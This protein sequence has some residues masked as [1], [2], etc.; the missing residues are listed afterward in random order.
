MFSHKT[1][2]RTALLIL[3]LTALQPQARAQKKEMAQAKTSIKSGKNLA[4]AEKLMTTLLQ[5]TANRTNTKIWLLLFETVKKQYEQANEKFYLHQS[6]DTTALFKAARR[7]FEVAEQ[8]DSIDAAPRADGQVEPKYRRK[9][10]DYLSPYRPN[11]LNGG[12]YFLGKQDFPTAY[13]FLDTYIGCASAPLFSDFRYA[14]N[15]R[16]LSRAAQLT[17]YCGLKQQRPD[18]ALRH[19]ELARRDTEHQEALLQYLAEV[20]K[21][22]GDTA[23]YVSTLREGFTLAPRSLYF[24]PH[25]FD[26]YFHRSDLTAAEALCD[27]ALQVAPTDVVFRFAKSSVLLSQTRYAECIALSDSLIAQN[28]SLADAYL[29]AGLSYYYQGTAIENNTR[30]ARAQRQQMLGYYRQALPYLQRYRTLQPETIDQW[31]LPLYTIYLN[32][33]MGKEF[34]EVDRLLKSRK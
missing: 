12:L 8:F 11:L 25:L 21:L 26:H 17:V 5:D 18:L 4:E 30:T 32:L 24:F 20:Y 29:N 19:A 23:A 33:N 13:E 16:Q 2:L 28:D 22:Q 10:A 15:D 6:A 3:A 31:G 7:M 34:D 9:H 14:E 27:S 1:I